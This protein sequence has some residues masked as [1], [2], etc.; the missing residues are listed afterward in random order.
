[1]PT[2]LLFENLKKLLYN[3]SVIRKEN[4]LQMKIFSTPLNGVDIDW[5][6]Q[7]SCIRPR[8]FCELYLERTLR[9]GEP[10]LE[11]EKS[12]GDLTSL[13]GVGKSSDA[14][15]RGQKARNSATNIL[16]KE[17]FI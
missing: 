14:S 4:L 3:I 13:C 8:L 15:L 1:M 6:Q 10:H 2:K 17:R 7:L 5:R 11:R 9:V 12:T 16:F